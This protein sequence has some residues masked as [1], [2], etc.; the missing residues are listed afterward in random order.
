MGVVLMTSSNYGYAKEVTAGWGAMDFNGHMANT[1]YLDVAAD[2]RMAF[3]A[4][5]GFPPGEL[6]RLGLGPVMRNDELEYVREVGLYDTITVTHAVLGM[7]QDGSRFIVENEI[8]AAS[9]AR[10]ATVRSTGGWIDLRSR[11][12]VAP[13]EPLLA[14]LAKVPRAR[15]FREL[16]PVSQ[17]ERAGDRPAGKDDGAVNERD[18]YRILVGAHAVDLDAVHAFLRTSYWAECIP[19]EIVARSIRGSLPFSLFSGDEQVGFA[20]V[21]TDRATYAY[22][23]DVYVL[24]CHRGRGLGRWLIATVMA[25]P[26]VQGLR[27]FGLMTR[28]AHSLYRPFGFDALR[29]PERYMEIARPGLYMQRED[30]RGLVRGTQD[31]A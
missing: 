28:N 7:S 15:G 8:L 29:V 2:V 14:T 17:A 23:S 21:I 3:F 30:G 13:P 20:R 24:E 1:A 26:A 12:L 10:A 6:R 16:P 5:H 22:L 9:G 18:G 31:G 27:R 25:H 19:R 11:K 4:E